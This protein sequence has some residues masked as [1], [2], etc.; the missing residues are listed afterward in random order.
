MHYLA[1]GK[2]FHQFRYVPNVNWKLHAGPLITAESRNLIKE[3]SRNCSQTSIGMLN[4]ARDFLAQLGISDRF[5]ILESPKSGVETR[6]VLFRKA[7][8][9]HSINVFINR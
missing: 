1:V 3:N 7:H 9:N 4:S 8:L 5:D 2:P 6:D